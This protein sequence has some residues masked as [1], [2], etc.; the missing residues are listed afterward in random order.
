M[1]GLR[2]AFVKEKENMEINWTGTSVEGASLITSVPTESGPLIP[3]RGTMPVC[4]LLI[5]Q[6]LDS[7]WFLLTVLPFDYLDPQFL[8]SITSP[9]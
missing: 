7:T 3:E 1:L 6:L 2:A 4:E 5:L 8:L 9:H